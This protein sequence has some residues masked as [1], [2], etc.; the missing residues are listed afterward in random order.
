MFLRSLRSGLATGLR[1]SRACL[2]PQVQGNSETPPGWFLPGL[3]E[4][5]ALP[6]PL[7]SACPWSWMSECAWLSDSLVG[8][9]AQGQRLTQGPGF[10]SPTRQ[11]LGMGEGRV[12]EQCSE[13]AF[14]EA[15]K[16]LS[17]KEGVSKEGGWDEGKGRWGAGLEPE[18][19]GHAC[20]STAGSDCRTCCAAAP[21]SASSDR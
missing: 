4:D 7:H 6:S 12:S 18:H 10:L 2:C 16:R 17:Q 20:F 1:D 9:G 5:R 15:G 11:A 14:W 21:Q 3:P 19:R 8:S 13:R